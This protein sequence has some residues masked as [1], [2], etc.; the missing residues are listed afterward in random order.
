MYLV[1]WSVPPEF[2]VHVFDPLSADGSVLPVFAVHVFD[3]LSADRAVLP[4]CAVHVFNP[5]STDGSVLPVLAVYVFDPL[6]ADGSVLSVFAVHVFFPGGTEPEGRVT[7]GHLARVHLTGVYRLDVLLEALRGGVPV[8]AQGAL[9]V[10]LLNRLLG[11]K[12]I[13]D[14]KSINEEVPKNVTTKFP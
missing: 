2:A 3:P 14:I 12:I 6:S 7:S 5:L 4:V 9:K 1:P 10:F 8:H 13:K 11:S